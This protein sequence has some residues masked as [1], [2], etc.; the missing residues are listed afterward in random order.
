M[1][2]VLLFLHGGQFDFRSVSVVSPTHCEAPWYLHP[3]VFSALLDQA[4]SF[5]LFRCIICWAHLSKPGGAFQV[6]K[7]SHWIF[8][9]VLRLNVLFHQ[10]LFRDLPDLICTFGLSVLNFLRAIDLQTLNQGGSWH[11]VISFLLR[12]EKVARAIFLVERMFLL[13]FFVKAVVNPKH[14]CVPIGPSLRLTFS[15]ALYLVVIVRQ[16]SYW[17]SAT[18]TLVALYDL[19]LA[20]QLTENT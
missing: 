20:Q 19:S 10:V 11:R 1:S 2:I 17:T 12:L 8:D 7:W 4:A 13:Y 3:F 9:R 15:T 14:R 16:A 18:I 5:K 6:E